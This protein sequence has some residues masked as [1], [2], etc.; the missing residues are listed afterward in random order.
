MGRRSI[1]IEKPI[2][3]HACTSAESVDQPGGTQRD[4][5]RVRTLICLLLLTLVVGTLGIT[6]IYRDPAF[7]ALDE[8]THADYAWKISHGELPHAGSTISSEILLLWTCHGQDNWSGIPSCG[9]NTDSSEFLGG[10][11]NYNFKHPPVYYAVTGLGAR[12][13]SAILPIDFVTAARLMSLLWVWA[14]LVWLFFILQKLRVQNT[15][16]L[17]VSI[18]VMLFP[19]ILTAA[20]NVTPDAAA[21]VSGVAAIY[22]LK[23]TFVD[24]KPKIWLGFLLGLFAASTKIMNSVAVLSAAGVIILVGLF[25]KNAKNSRL[26]LTSVG[27]ATLVGVIAVY[28][29]W[30]QIQAQRAIDGWVSPIKGVNTHPVEGLPV[31][32][33]LSTFFKGFNLSNGGY[34]GSDITA[35]LITLWVTVLTLVSISVGVL[36]YFLVKNDSS[37]KY[38]PLALSIGLLSW[39]T[40]VQIEVLTMYYYYFKNIS[41]RYGNSLIPLLC[42]V[43]ALVARNQKI[44]VVVKSL[45]LVG[46]VVV[47]AALLGVANN[48]L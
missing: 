33:W 13:L 10:G 25:A 20:T 19:S 39:P 6:K 29:G 5:Y 31:D 35:W 43:V 12:A 44:P 9:S 48:G 3:K 23:V 41:Q 18:L 46:I 17:S 14:G 2:S 11:E 47:F 8:Q 42:L 7:S 16:A 34:F 27:I 30:K 1:Q 38:F 32:E 24:R 21:V 4:S 40:L 36:G 28:I 26:K 37:E 15:L 45:V 22:L